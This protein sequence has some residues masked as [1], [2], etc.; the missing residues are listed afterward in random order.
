MA[1]CANGI[2][3][4][5]IHEPVERR[6]G[7]NPQEIAVIAALDGG[8]E[9]GQGVVGHRNRNLSWLLGRT[10]TLPRLSDDPPRALGGADQND[11]H[12]QGASEFTPPEWTLPQGLKHAAC[13]RARA[14]A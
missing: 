10:A 5:E 14:V 4:V 12:A 11:P 1:C 2:V 3:G 6:L 9:W 8:Q 13:F 7:E